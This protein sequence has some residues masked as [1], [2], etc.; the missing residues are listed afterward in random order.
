MKQNTPKQIKDKTIG[1]MVDTTLYKKIKALAAI[2]D[3]SVSQFLRIL[4]EKSV[5]KA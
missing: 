1:V 5:S 3:R 4:I 2:E